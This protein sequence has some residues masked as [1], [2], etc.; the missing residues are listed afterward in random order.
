MLLQYTMDIVEE[1]KRKDVMR[2]ISNAEEKSF[3]ENDVTLQ[4]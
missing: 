2:R 1:I 3:K 4:E